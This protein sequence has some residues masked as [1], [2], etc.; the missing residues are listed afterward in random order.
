M[1]GF[2]GFFLN[3]K[4]AASGMHVTT[5]EERSFSSLSSFCCGFINELEGRSSLW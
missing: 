3:M 5:V 1:W 2:F 4:F